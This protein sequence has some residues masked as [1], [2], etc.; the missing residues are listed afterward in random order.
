MNNFVS[1]L[2]SFIAAIIFPA[3]SFSQSAP[4]VTATG[5]QIYCP[6]TPLPIVTEFNITNTGTALA[7]AIYIQISSGYVNGTDLLSLSSTIPNVVTSWNATSGKL[8]ISGAGGQELPYTTLINAVANVVYTNTAANPSGIRTFSIPLGEANYL[9]S[10]QHYYRFIP[11]VGITWTAARTAAENSTYYGLQGYLATLLAED[12]AQLCGEQATG[13]GWIGGSD[14]ETEGVWKWVTGPEAG[15]TFWNGMVNGS[16]PNFAFWNTGEPNSSGDED[17]AHI[18]APGVGIPGSWNDLPNGGSGGPYVP[19]G[20]IVEYGGM[21]GDPVLQISASTTISHP[22]I[23]GTTPGSRC[24]AGTVLLQATANHSIVR[25][26]STPTGGTPLSTGSSFTT[27]VLTQSATYYASPYES[28][29]NAPRIPIIATINPLPTITAPPSVSTCGQLPAVLTATPSSGTINWYATPAG[30]VAVS[31]GS[32]FTTTVTADTVFYAE[33][34]SLEGCISNTRAAVNV[35]VTPLPTVTTITPVSNCG[36]GAVLLEATPSAGIVNWYDQP[37][38]GTL[39]G[40]GNSIISPEVT[41]NTTFYA[42]AVNGTCVS[43]TRSAVDVTISPQPTVTAAS[44]LFICSEGTTTLQ[45][46]GTEGTI[47][48]YDQPVAGMMIGTGNSITSPYL[49]ETTTFYAEATNAGCTSI[50][51]PV[52]VAIIPPPTIVS[53]PAVTACE[54]SPTMLIANP[55]AGSVNWYIE[56]EGG[57]MIG[58]GSSIESPIITADTT[59]YAQAIH[60][61]C[62]SDTRTPVPVTMF[63][64]PQVNNEVTYFC[65]YGYATLDAGLEDMDYQWLTGASSQS[66]NVAEPG[67]YTVEVTNL[68]GCSAVKTFTVIRRNAPVIDGVGVGTG[69]SIMIIMENEDTS[70][71]EYSINGTDYQQSNTF[72]N[73][74]SG[75][76][77]AYVREINGCGTDSATYR[78]NLVP[79]FFSPNNDSYND[80]FTIAKMSSYPKATLYIFDRYGKL[81]SKLDQRNRTWDGTYNGKL[82]PAADYWYVLKLDEQSPE[83]RGHFSLMR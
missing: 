15:T 14:A 40:I 44:P 39:I 26:Y 3:N 48:W 42:E 49:T 27:P 64:I 54:G 32:T 55:S 65:E 5:N 23:T 6:G 71:F 50:R 52:E 53:A 47:S 31:T 30:G 4:L 34:V 2:L 43:A 1:I 22:A 82:L 13:T 73:L 11:S 63:A 37:A 58:S 77:T 60:N 10:T 59:F 20:Y 79:K 72:T 78:I 35:I 66:I 25:W 33:A 57:T 45:A 74:P 38:G 61:G 9:P 70:D 16:T 17:Y 28:S 80:L 36:S 76:G 8:T 75:S 29:C 83:I 69:A 18:T 62:L 81:L 46:T 41:A 51:I 7:E 68:A 19:M 21:P 12:E 56:A 67:T 24:G